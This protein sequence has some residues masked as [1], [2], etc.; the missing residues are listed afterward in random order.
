M[1]TLSMCLFFSGINFTKEVVSS[2]GPT[3]KEFKSKLET[4]EAVR[5]RI[6]DIKGRV[7]AFAEKFPMPG[8]DEL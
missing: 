4:D 1:S 2:C 3:L 5:A 8:F 6:Q 7:E